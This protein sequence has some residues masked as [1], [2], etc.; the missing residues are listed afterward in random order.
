VQTG[1]AGDTARPSHGGRRLASW[2]VVGVAADD[3]GSYGRFGSPYGEA[4]QARATRSKAIANPHQGQAKLGLRG[5]GVA[6]QRRPKP[7]HRRTTI[8]GLVSCAFEC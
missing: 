5:V 6:S 2:C 1:G 4:D 3:G 8:N 7:P